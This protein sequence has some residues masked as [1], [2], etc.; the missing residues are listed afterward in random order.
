[1]HADAVE[2]AV[3]ELDVHEQNGHLVASAAGFRAGGVG[4]RPERECN[5][6]AGVAEEGA[7]P[8]AAAG[9]D[10]VGFGWGLMFL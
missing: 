4:Q 10:N 8:A 5:R 7:R 2:G 9:D 1:M 6:R 3:L